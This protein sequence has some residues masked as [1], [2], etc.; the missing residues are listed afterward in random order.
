M[1]TLGKHF[2][3]ICKYILPG[4]GRLLSKGNNSNLKPIF[5]LDTAA[6]RT[7]SQTVNHGHL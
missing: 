7:V 4:R 5:I 6:E 2:T 3:Q 1:Y